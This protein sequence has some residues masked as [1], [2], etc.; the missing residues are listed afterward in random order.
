M[1]KFKSV[2]TY[3]IFI[4]TPFWSLLDKNMKFNGILY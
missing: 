3:K 2:K 1:N 4:F